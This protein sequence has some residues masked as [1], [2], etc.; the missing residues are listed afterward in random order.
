MVIGLKVKVAGQVIK[1]SLNKTSIPSVVIHISISL[2]GGK[3]LPTDDKK[4]YIGAKE[5]A[6]EVIGDDTFGYVYSVSWFTPNIVKI[7]DCAQA[8][9]NKKELDSIR[10]YASFIN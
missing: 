6:S 10:K 5:S 4:E 1:Y 2:S 7:L 9:F 8:K 3:V